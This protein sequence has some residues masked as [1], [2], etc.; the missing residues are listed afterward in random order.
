MP[1]DRHKYPRTFHLPWSPGAT[2]DDHVLDDTSAF[3]G[4]EV[5]CL[6]KLDGENTSIYADG[7][8][9]ARSL[10]SGPHPSRMLVRT[11]ARHIRDAGMPESLRLCG[12]NLYAQH[13]IAYR[14]L[15]RHFLVFGIYDGETCLSWDAVAEWCALLN[16]PIVPV[17]YR[18]VWDERAVRACWTGRSTASPGDE[19]EGFVVRLADAFPVSEFSTSVAK[20]VRANHVQTDE[21]W[22]HKAVI[23]NGLRDGCIRRF[24]R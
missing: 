21:H 16:Q 22:M 17:L 19:Q 11:L 15:L 8:S 14:Q 23:P 2:N 12:E 1:V 6:E 20:F 5:V 18:G 3:V 4:R 13:S 7:Y 24:S 10:D 9:H